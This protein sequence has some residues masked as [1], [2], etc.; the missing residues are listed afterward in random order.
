MEDTNQSCEPLQ[1]EQ[2]LGEGSRGEGL[3]L[4]PLPLNLEPSRTVPLRLATVKNALTE[5][6]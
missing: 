5:L 2:M 1:L 3:P 6:F 4:C